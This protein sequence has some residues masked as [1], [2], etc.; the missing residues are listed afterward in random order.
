MQALEALLLTSGAETSPADYTATF[1]VHA[2]QMHA[3]DNVR[4]AT[5]A[6]VEYIEWQEGNMRPVAEHYPGQCLMHFMRL[7]SAPSESVVAFAKKWGVLRAEYS[8]DDDVKQALPDIWRREAISSWK[9]RAKDVRAILTF[10]ADIRSGDRPSKSTIADMEFKFKGNL[11]PGSLSQN[12]GPL[13][14]FLVNWFGFL[15]FK[16]G[17]TWDKDNK[18]PQVHLHVDTDTFIDDLIAFWGQMD[19]RKRLDQEAGVGAHRS[20][21]SPLFATLCLSLLAVLTSRQGVYRCSKCGGLFTATRT[22]RK[23]KRRFCSTA[24]QQEAENL[25]AR[26]AMRRKR[27]SGLPLTN[28]IQEAG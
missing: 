28:S 8:W 9:R 11:W 3:P 16:T 12:S 2:P 24:C 7:E 5:R 23:D 22:P 20:P 19:E 27:S 1:S 25:D 15:S 10:Y 21:V 6:G 4:L 14:I 17:V 26:D 18:F 13:S